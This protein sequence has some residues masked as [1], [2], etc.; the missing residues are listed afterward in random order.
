MRRH[1]SNRRAKPYEEIEDDWFSVLSPDDREDLGQVVQDEIERRSA[2]I[3]PQA[4]Q[5]LWSPGILKLSGTVAAISF[6]FVIA[7]FL[8]T[9]SST[10][11]SSSAFPGQSE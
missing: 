7:F 5:W 11:K 4:T 10:G 3:A 1:F 6:A 9:G 2:V 8:L